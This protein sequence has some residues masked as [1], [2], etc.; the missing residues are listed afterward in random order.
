MQNPGEREN[1]FCVF[2]ASTLKNECLSS[3]DEFSSFTCLLLKATDILSLLQSMQCPSSFCVSPCLFCAVCSASMAFF[4]AIERTF[5][6][7]TSIFTMFG[8]GSQI[9]LCICTLILCLHCMHM[10]QYLCLQI[11]NIKELYFKQLQIILVFVCIRL[12]VYIQHTGENGDTSKT[13]V[14]ALDH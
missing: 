14:A 3:L 5:L 1:E 2:S 7:I 8:K 11:Q 13:E 9:S 12:L 10:Q 4:P 6:Q